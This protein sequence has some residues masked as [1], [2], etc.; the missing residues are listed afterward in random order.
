MKGWV[1]W[2]VASAFFLALYDLAK[3]ASVRNNAVLPVLLCSTSF[4]ALAYVVGI[5]L[6]GRCGAM[7]SAVDGR[8]F[9]LGL[10]KSVIVASSWVFTFCALRTL[11]ITVATPI[12]ASSPALVFL[13][14]CFLYGEIP[15]PLQ[16]LGMAL[17]FAGYWTFSWAGKHEGIDFLH[18]RAVGFAV[19]GAVLSAVSSL[20]DKFVFQVMRSPV[21]PT[22]LVFQLGLIAVYALCLFATRILKPL[23]P[24]PTP[25]P[26]PPPPPTPTSSSPSTSTHY[27]FTWRW[28]IPLVGI[29]LAFADWLMFNG[30]AIQGTP[31]SIAA[32]MR[33]F[34]VA[35]TF[36]LGA[37]FF[38]E[39]NLV[40]KSIALALVLSGIAL[41]CFKS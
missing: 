6:T 31:V 39:T 41:L 9:A 22:Q 40:R 4:G 11:P 20:W 29:L 24:P 1:L 26:T 37:F 3:K 7:F 34:S 19:A 23:P 38:R 16:G 35:I 13:V 8:V 33:R 28:T 5:A 21:E 25:P 12:R 15:S 14:A 27:A 2:I 32:L 17:V 30:L 10:S 36:V 18:N